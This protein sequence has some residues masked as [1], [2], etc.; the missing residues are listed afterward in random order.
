MRIVCTIPGKFGDILWAMATVRAIAETYGE[1]VEVLTSDAYRSIC[2]LLEQQSYVL[3]AGAWKA[4]QVQD[5][6]PMS[7]RIPPGF[8][9]GPPGHWDRVFHLG[10]D[11]WPQLPLPLEHWRLAVKQREW[12]PGD[13]PLRDVELGRAWITT[14]T[15]THKHY[16]VVGFTDEHFE[17]KYGLTRL[18]NQQQQLEPIT[19][20]GTR[21]DT[22][23]AT[24]LLALTRGRSYAV[25]CDWVEA[26]TWITNA[27]VF[28]GC[29]SAL[30]VLAVALG[31]PVVLMEP[32]PHRHHQIFYPLGDTGPQVTL[33]RGNDGKPT[34]DARH[35]AQVLEETLKRVLEV[36][37]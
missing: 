28:L 2:P 12:F 4:W 15:T 7:P 17:L 37:A 27:S 29:N 26:A 25:A 34:F 5:T 31:V 14:P 36:R 11:G 24:S 8:S 13:P 33:V 16:V 22:E 1:P 21:W 35:V 3:K 9:Q 30:H 6:A 19:A 23:V 20:P 18:V 10:Y 32:S